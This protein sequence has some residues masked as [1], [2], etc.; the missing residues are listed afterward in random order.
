MPSHKSYMTLNVKIHV[1][2]FTNMFFLIRSDSIHRKTARKSSFQKVI[3]T[4]LGK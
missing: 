1:L 3:H 4:F 2:T